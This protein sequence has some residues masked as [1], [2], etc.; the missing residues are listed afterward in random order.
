MLVFFYESGP[1][2]GQVIAVARLHAVYLSLCDDVMLSSLER[3]AL[4]NVELTKIGKTKR[5]TVMVIDNIFPLTAPV[6]RAKL[7]A[8]GLERPN[9]FLT[10][11]VLTSEQLQYLLDEGFTL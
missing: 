8:Q 10:T 5:R 11:K 1:K 4:T 3:T 6:S 9:D 2:S 7:S